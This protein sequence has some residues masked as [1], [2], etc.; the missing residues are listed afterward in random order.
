MLR[1]ICF[2]IWEHVA[3]IKLMPQMA[4]DGLQYR[5]GCSIPGLADAVGDDCAVVVEAVGDFSHP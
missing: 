4:I 5:V 1:A 3:L 2:A